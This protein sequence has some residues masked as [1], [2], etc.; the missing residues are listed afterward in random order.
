[1]KISEQRLRNSMPV[2]YSHPHPTLYPMRYPT[3]S[4]Y[5]HSPAI[6]TLSFKLPHTFI[7]VPCPISSGYLCFYLPSVH[8]VSTTFLISNGVFAFP[9]ISLQLSSRPVFR[10]CCRNGYGYTFNAYLSSANPNFQGLNTC[11]G[12]QWRLSK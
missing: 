2:K 12:S 4:S 9:F 6:S 5:I 3:S 10:H 7:H 1:M 11:A 8:Y